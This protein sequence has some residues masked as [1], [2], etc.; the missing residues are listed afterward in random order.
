MQLQLRKK[1]KEQEESKST[2]V[3]LTHDTQKCRKAQYWALER[4]NDVVF[5]NTQG[6]PPNP[7]SSGE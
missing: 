4:V 6:I 3:L 1:I 2:D 7:C 5:S